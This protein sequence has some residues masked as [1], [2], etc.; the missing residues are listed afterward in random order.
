MSFA[1]A[2]DVDHPPAGRVNTYTDSAPVPGAVPTTIVSPFALTDT[3]FPNL[4]NAVR[5]GGVSVTA[6]PVVASAVHPVDGFVNTYT[7]PTSRLVL[8]STCL[9]AMTTVFPSA[10]TDTARP[11]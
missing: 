6:L 1:D 7:S 11:N 5:V 4:S 10:L 2:A 8:W 3:E 9:A